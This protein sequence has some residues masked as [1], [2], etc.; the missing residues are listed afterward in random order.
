MFDKD[1][2]M[3]IQWR[4]AATLDANSWN[5]NSVF[6][7]EMKLLERSILLQGFIQPILITADGMIIDGF[8]RSRLALESK[9]LLERYQ[10]MVPCAVLNINRPEAMVITI[11]MNRAK[12]SHVAYRMA[13]IIHELIDVHQY[14]PAE[15]AVE[16]GA[17]LDE[18]ALLHQDGVFKAKDIANYSFSKAWYPAEVAKAKP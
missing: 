3:N 12:G 4:D 5:P 13:E 10:R 2:I 11:R 16:I 1:P 6:S 18:V 14:E 17:T 8:H 7:P 15:I 9:M